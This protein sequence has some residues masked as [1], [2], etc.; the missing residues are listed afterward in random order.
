MK[1][2]Y[3]TLNKLLLLKILFFIFCSH[4][5]CFSQNEINH[6]SF[7][8]EGFGKPN[9]K[10][11]IYKHNLVKGANILVTIDEKESKRSNITDEEFKLLQSAILKI[12]LKDVLS[13]S[14]WVSTGSWT[15]EISFGSFNSGRVIY[16]FGN[17]LKDTSKPEYNDVF[18][19]IKMILKYAN[20]TIPIFID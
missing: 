5:T 13:K 16:S 1:N 12:N 2:K 14:N 18:L 10:I 9:Y 6:I 3:F 11:L 20:L 7:T 17:L 15:T 19:V 4:I 8:H